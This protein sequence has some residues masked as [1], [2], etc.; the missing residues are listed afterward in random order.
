MS[1]ESA[2][3]GVF[4]PYPLLAI[5]M[6][7]VMALGGGLIGLYTQLSSMNTTM[8]LRDGDYQRQLQEQKK[9]IELL[10]VYVQNDREKLI[11]L[12]SAA[13]KRRN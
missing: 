2:K 12:E 4:I 11:K 10:Q 13:E 5:L 6:G 1:E 3:G 9:T 7:L 8:L